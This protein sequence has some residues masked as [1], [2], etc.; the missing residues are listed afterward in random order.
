MNKL[1][2][3]RHAESLYNQAGLWAGITDTPLS[4]HGEDEARLMG[5]KIRDVKPDAEWEVLVSPLSRAQK[6]AALAIE[7][8]GIQV[9]GWKVCEEITERDYGDYTG[10]NKWQVREQVGE[11]EFH[12]IRRSFDYPI[13]NGESLKQVYERVI[14]WY[15]SFVVPLLKRGEDVM[16]VAHGNSLRALIKYLENISDEQISHFELE[17]AKPRVYIYH[18][19][20]VDHEHRE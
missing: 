13:P 7:S 10:L 8:A 9:K 6:T 5:R 12:R 2:L 19:G 20:H 14:T 1:V 15:E 11:E 4:P 17:T 18:N 3:I 16:I